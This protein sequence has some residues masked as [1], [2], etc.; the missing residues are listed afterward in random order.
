M[1]YLHRINLNELKNCL[2][3][4]ENEFVTNV[5]IEKNACN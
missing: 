1:M 2:N 5:D 3:C 4:N